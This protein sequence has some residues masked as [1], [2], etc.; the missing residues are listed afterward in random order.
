M[1]RTVELMSLDMPRVQDGVAMM[2][3]TLQAAPASFSKLA[4]NSLKRLRPANLL[5]HILFTKSDWVATAEA[6]LERILTHGGVFHF[7]GHSWEIDEMGQWQNVER[8]FALV[9]QCGGHARFTDNTGLSNL[10]MP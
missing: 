2:P 1:A 4:R 3:T 8:V 9:A 7:W 10:A 6:V 5:R